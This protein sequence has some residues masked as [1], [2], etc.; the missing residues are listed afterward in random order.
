MMSLAL[1]DLHFEVFDAI[2]MGIALYSVADEGADFV[3]EALN[4][5]AL[6]ISEV[7][8]EDAIGRRLTEVFPGAEESGFPNALR[9]VY[10]SG[11]DLKVPPFAY[12]DANRRQRW[13]ENSL[14]RLSETHIMAVYSDVTERIAFQASLDES[15]KRYSLLT[16]AMADGVW[17]WDVASG[18]TYF[19][20][21]WKQQL[22]YNPND[23]EN[24]FATWRD[25]LHASD[26]RR[27]MDDLQAFLTGEESLWEH[28]FRLRQRDGLYRWIRARGTA[29]RDEQG[30]VTRIIGVHIDIDQM[31]HADQ[32]RSQ[33]RQLLEAIHRALPDLFFLLDRRGCILAYQGDDPARLMMAPE[34]FIGR[35]VVDL[36]PEDVGRQHEAAYQ[37]AFESGEVETFEYPLLVDGIERM[38]EARVRA[39]SDRETL[40]AIVRDITDQYALRHAQAQRVK[41]LSSL[42]QV[43]RAALEERS[44]EPFAQRVTQAIVEAMQQPAS[45]RVVLTVGGQRYTAGNSSPAG[46]VCLQPIGADGDLLGEIRVEFGLDCPP[47]Q[48]ERNFLQG[49]SRTISLWLQS[50]EAR[51]RSETYR[52]IVSSTQDMVA[53][54]DIEARYEIVNEAYAAH[55]D[56]STAEMVGL[57]AP[58]VLGRT[59]WREL[60]S[61][62]F[63]SCLAGSI[64]V[65]QEWRETP[66]GPRYYNIIYAPLSDADGIRGVVVSGHDITELDAART[67]LRRTS[68]VF[69]DSSEAIF[70]ISPLGVIEDVNAATE[71]ITGRERSQLIGVQAG[72]LIADSVSHEFRATALAEVNE[73][74]HWHGEM[75]IHR[76]DGEEVPGLLTVSLMRTD[77]AADESDVTGYSL[78]FTDISEIKATEAQLHRMAHEDALTGLPNRTQMMRVIE[79]NIELA[80]RNEQ[81]FSVMFIDLDRFKD[82][83]DTLGHGAGDQLLVMASERLRSVVRANDLLA[84]V[85]GD[86]FVAVFPGLGAGGNASIIAE[87]MIAAMS[88]P[89]DLEGRATRVSASVGIASF[90]GDGNTTELLLRNADTAM[91][92]AKA[93]GRAAWCCYSDEMTQKA[94]RHLFLVSGLRQAIANDQGL[95]MVYQ[96]QFDI[97]SGELSGFEALLRWDHPE[98]GVIAPT[99][100]IPAAEESALIKTLDGWVVER[101]CRDLASHGVVGRGL[102]V[103]VNVGG[104]SLSAPSFM[105][106]TREALE[107]HGVPGAL[108]EL[109]VSER[110][111]LNEIDAGRLELD[112]LGSLDIG[113]S[114]DDFGTSYS[115]LLQLKRLPVRRLKI[116]GDFVRELPQQPDGAAIT[117]AIIAIGRSLE[118][119]VVAEGIE[120]QDQVE[121]LGDHSG[122]KAQGYLYGEPVEADELSALL[123]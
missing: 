47:E 58:D 79:R 90:P 120:T 18:Q 119:E 68:R 117:A 26:R 41:E 32:E 67:T 33:Q 27:V 12:Q 52:Q 101:V 116:D 103:S 19:S 36:F 38:F 115:S 71:V 7:A 37:R 83:N 20:P 3:I 55:V 59:H 5:T 108:L 34:T 80:T 44:L 29:L 95:R 31:K 43:Q 100:F 51:N 57:S 98:Q 118:L 4:P 25:L 13:F 76:P 78:V 21:G 40:S 54:L 62:H 75:T 1:H 72:E 53:L 122:L 104:A 73:T 84:R 2:P 89:F 10:R 23:L 97:D 17:D 88:N 111:L 94:A 42:F 99:E 93:S 105:T 87:K 50:A 46:E 35:R 60:E 70:F 112:W 107:R 22:G 64:E 110:A 14:I 91:Y 61:S 123:G 28:D 24:T 81:P 113:L 16:E 92:Q 11:E 102:G 82:I 86:E 106:Q 30:A 39:S 114:V 96:P 6:E 69:S 74:G 45:V 77:P 56:R 121:C 109:E 66:D 9:Q 48:E 85:G 8:L 63:E 15:R 65:F 49:A